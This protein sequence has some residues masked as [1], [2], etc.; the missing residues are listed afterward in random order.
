MNERKQSILFTSQ[1]G[2]EIDESVDR[3]NSSLGNRAEVI[4]AEGDGIGNLV[5]TTSI[6]KALI[7]S[8]NKRYDKSLETIRDSTKDIFLIHLHCSFWKRSAFFTIV[9]RFVSDLKKSIDV[10]GVVTLIDDFYSVYFRIR[11]YYDSND[12][13]DNVNPIDLLYWRAVDVMLGQM[14]ANQ[15]GVPHFVVSV[16]HPLKL[17]TKLLAVRHVTVYAGHPITDIRKWKKNGRVQLAD[18]LIQRINDSFLCELS[19]AESFV[20]FLPDAIDEYPILDLPQKRSQ[21]HSIIWPRKWLAGD[22]PIARP[23]R[24]DLVETYMGD[25]SRSISANKETYEDAVS[26]HVADRDY[27]LVNQSRNFVFILLKQIRSS[28]GVEAELAQARY[29]LKDTYFFNPD[30]IKKGKHNGGRPAWATNLTGESDDL[31]HLMNIVAKQTEAPL[32]SILENQA[33]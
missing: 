17:L 20:T 24:D 32:I 10:K 1:S 7:D 15:A 21:L 18:R 28:G 4:C 29:G 9:D 11:N 2:L 16:N 13:K 30:K 6:S 25:L 8:I 3:L 26:G 31:S 23:P 22:E 19:Q 33:T 27:R 14:I 5:R 12:I